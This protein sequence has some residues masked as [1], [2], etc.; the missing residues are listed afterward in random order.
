[1]NNYDNPT[2]IEQTKSGERGFDLN[3]RLLKDR[4]IMLTGVIDDIS[5]TSVISKLLYLDMFGEDDIKL[6]INSPGGSVTAGLA[7]YDTMNL[8]KCNVSTYGMGICASMGAFLLSS[9]EKTKR[10]MLPNSFSMI[11][12]VSGGAYGTYSDVERTVGF[13]ESLNEN[14]TSILAKNCGKKKSVMKKVSD[15][16]KYMSAKESVE[17]GLVDKILK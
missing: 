4:I 5:A 12:Q 16:D 1:M 2:V 8:I 17:F 13:M 15:R 11:H 6:Y 7:V 9:G 10:H 14:L 3:S